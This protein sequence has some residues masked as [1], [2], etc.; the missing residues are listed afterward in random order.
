MRKRVLDFREGNYELLILL[1]SMMLALVFLYQLGSDCEL[2][3]LSGMPQSFSGDA[4]FGGFVLLALSNFIMGIEAAKSLDEIADTK[5]YR[6]ANRAIKRT[7]LRARSCML[8][9]EIICAGAAAL[10]Y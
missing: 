6:R 4:V 1:A 9:Q 7:Y 8:A 10:V 2:S 5:Q 3:N